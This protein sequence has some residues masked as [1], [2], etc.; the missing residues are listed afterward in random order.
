MG[1]GWDWGTALGGGL[2]LGPLGFVGGGLAGGSTND[3]TGNS[4][5]KDASDWLFGTGES[6]YQ[7]MGS[8][9][10]VQWLEKNPGT[11]DAMYAQLGDQSAEAKGNMGSW[12]Q[13][14]RGLNLN[15]EAYDPNAYYNQFLG[16][17]GQL[18]DL[19]S[20]QMSPLTQSLNAVAARQA[21][22]GGE[23]ALFAMPGARNSGAGMA[24]FGQAYAD[25]YAQALAQLQ[26]AQLQGTLGLWGNA[27]GLNSSGQQ[28]KT[29]QANQAAQAQYAQQMQAA[30]QMAAMYGNLY[31]QFS[32]Q[33]AGMAS[34]QM[35][36]WQPTYAATSPD[37]G[38]L[39]KIAPY[40]PLIGAFL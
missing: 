16:Q 21:A 35:A 12:E 10:D 26:S 7:T 6:G 1:I 8:P 4:Y 33:Q 9:N 14:L 11:W 34:D 23:A 28:F 13:Y 30:Q 18:A 29:A 5:V 25:P 3:S 31:G 17:S 37:T 2:A 15:T 32:G 40:A 24:A 19:V 22:L 38:F 36:M 27:L 20:G 39:G